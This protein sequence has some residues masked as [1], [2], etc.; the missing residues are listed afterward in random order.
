MNETSQDLG[1]T[2]LSNNEK[3]NQFCLVFVSQ[4]INTTMPVSFALPKRYVLSMMIFGGFFAMSSMRVNL[5]VAIGAMVNNHTREINGRSFEK[6]RKMRY[7]KTLT[8]RL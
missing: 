5:N 2:T 8:T 7:C 6:V 4:L 1:V 3:H